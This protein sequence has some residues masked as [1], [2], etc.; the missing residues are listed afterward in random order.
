L[1]GI[2][3]ARTADHDR[4]TVRLD[5][6]EDYFEPGDGLLILHDPRFNANLT[7][8]GGRDHVKIH[9]RPGLMLIFPSYVWHS[10]TPHLGDFRRLAF[11]INVTF[12]W[13]GGPA[14]ER[15]DMA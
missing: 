11:S 6:A 13:P 3:Y 12:R 10:V 7:A 9:P 8:V 5:G 1:V 4:P 2:Y 14:P 15:L